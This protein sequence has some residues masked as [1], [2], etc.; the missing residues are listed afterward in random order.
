M[1]PLTISSLDAAVAL[2]EASDT[3]CGLVMDRRGFWLLV[4]PWNHEYLL[5]DRRKKRRMR[6]RLKRGGA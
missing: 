1:T 4:E 5:A 3:A 2:L 6:R